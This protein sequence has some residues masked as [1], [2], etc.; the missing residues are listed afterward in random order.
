MIRAI[1]I[2]AKGNKIV[3]QISNLSYGIYL[4]HIFVLGAVYTLLEGYLSTPCMIAS[5]GISTFVFCCIL[6]KLLSFLPRS[7]YIIG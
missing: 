1:F 7:K 2:G 3:I 4:M 5:I 6:S